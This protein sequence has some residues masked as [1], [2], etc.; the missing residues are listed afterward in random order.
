MNRNFFGYELEPDQLPFLNPLLVL[1][2]IPTMD[3]VIYPGLAR[4]GIKLAPLRRI[5]IGMFLTSMA[6]CASAVVEEAINVNGA[7]KVHVAFQLPQFLLLTTGEV[8]FSITGLEFGK[9]RK[10]LPASKW[11]I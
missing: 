2:L 3:N 4:C 9:T 11:A 6:F 1:L 7:D 5:A 8:M 10:N